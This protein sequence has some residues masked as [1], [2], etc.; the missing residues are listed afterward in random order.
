MRILIYNWRDMANFRAGG[1]EVYTHSVAK[2]WVEWG[3]DVTWFTSHVSG[4]PSAEVVDGIKIRRSGG[5]V[6]V[7]RAARQYY[8]REGKG[9]FDVVLDEVNTRPFLC[10]TFVEVPVVAL[11]HQVCR[12]VWFYESS[13]PVALLG[14]YWLEPRWLNNYKDIPVVTVSESSRRSLSRYGLSE[15]AVIPEGVAV[16]DYLPK[17]HKEVRPTVIFV[18]RLAKNK[19]PRDAIKACELAASQMPELQLWV[20]GTGPMERRLRKEA[21]DWVKFFGR[22]GNLEKFELMARAHAL[23]AT[24]VREGW[25]LTVSEAAAVGTTAIT[26]NVPGLCDSVA[27]SQGVLVDPSPKALAAALTRELPSLRDSE[28]APRNNG[29]QPWSY[30]AES[31][32]NHLLSAASKEPVR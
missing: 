19:R 9:C 5:R 27:A 26:Y 10:P 12:E 30:V 7:Y 20:V 24:S 21:P 32:L 6:G 18:A 23:V 4:H 1:A 14:R 13:L 16:P 28:Q 3:H 2:H 22:V 31:L 29:T 17:V 11:I 25:G 8:E 15:V